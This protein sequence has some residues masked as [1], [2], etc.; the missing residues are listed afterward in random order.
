MTAAKTAA[1]TVIIIRRRVK[2]E[3]ERDQR[4]CD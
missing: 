4:R 2:K 1:I 3:A